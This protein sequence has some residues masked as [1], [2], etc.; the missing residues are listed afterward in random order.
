MQVPYLESMTAAP[1]LK[2]KPHE[3]FTLYGN[4]ELVAFLFDIVSVLVMNRTPS[5]HPLD[6]SPGSCPIFYQ[7]SESAAL[8]PPSVV[9]PIHVDNVLDA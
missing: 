4:A 7:C 2:S 5:W 9:P 6:I 3:D 1:V 8:L